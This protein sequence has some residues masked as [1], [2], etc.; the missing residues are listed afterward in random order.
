MVQPPAPS[1]RSS[2][3]RSRSPRSRGADEIDFDVVVVGGGPCGATAA[4]DL[5]RAGHRVLLLDRA[6]R[7]KPCGGAVPPR[8]LEASVA[9]EPDIDPAARRRWRETPTWMA[10]HAKF[11]ALYDRPFWRDAG[12]A[13]WFAKDAAFDDALRA[14]INADGGLDLFPNQG[15]GVLTSTVWADGLIDNPAGNQ[16]KRGD[17]VRF[18][19]F[20]ELLT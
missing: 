20:S 10:P 8:L 1:L 11:F 5:A 13:K 9:F 14:R 2:S 12:P 6:G 19:P 3:G 4:W 7:I 18:L 15:S 17:V 16:I